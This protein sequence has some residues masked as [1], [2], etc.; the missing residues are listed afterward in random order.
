M[1]KKISIVIVL[2]GVLVALYFYNATSTDAA[3]PDQS[4]VVQNSDQSSNHELNTQ[5]SGNNVNDL[6]PIGEVSDEISVFN[7]YLVE[8][9]DS[10]GYSIGETILTNINETIDDETIDHAAA[11]LKK[12]IQNPQEHQ[13]LM[14]ELQ[15]PCK[16]LK[17]RENST[18][19][20]EVKSMIKGEYFLLA[21]QKS[22]FCANFGTENDP[23]FLTLDLARK[24]DKLAQL[25]LAED[26]GGAM[27]RG[28]ISPQLDPLEY[29]DLRNEVL[30]YLKQLSA[31]GVTQATITLH[32]LY[33]SNKFLVPQ[34][35]VLQYYYAVLGEKQSNSRNTF[36]LSSD[37]LY[38]RL[39]G[40]EKSRADR[41]TKK[42]K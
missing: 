23:F 10:L 42:L 18:L 33:R 29:N 40:S 15:S 36:M 32:N 26:L 24:G 9:V 2:I 39:T 1:M 7:Q 11:E 16:A 13:L 22:G 38:D 17:K 12:I 14:R 8:N 21:L 19:D 35:K 3:N 37:E 4:E 28:L 34:D 20:K 27:H 31:R 30:D 41:V 25:F 6:L 5:I